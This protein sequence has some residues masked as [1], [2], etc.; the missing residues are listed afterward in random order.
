M[1]RL[2]EESTD[3]SS[4]ESSKQCH[5]FDIPSTTADGRDESFASNQSMENSLHHLDHFQSVD[6][7]TLDVLDAPI[8]SVQSKFN[9]RN[10]LDA[11]QT[12]FANAR[13]SDDEDSSPPEWS[14]AVK[15]VSNAASVQQIDMPNVEQFLMDQ[16]LPP[17]SID[18]TLEEYSKVL[19]S[20]FDIPVVEG[21]IIESVCVLFVE[22]VSQKAL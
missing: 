20:F 7:D 13:S 6:F 19:C 9:L 15:E 2:L 22:Y 12:V 16:G 11:K 3:H 4:V 5:P 8:S 17:A 10:H 18:L 14:G 1:R 21:R